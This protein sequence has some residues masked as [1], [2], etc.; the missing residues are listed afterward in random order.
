M[1]ARLL[2]VMKKN[3]ARRKYAPDHTGVCC[4]SVVGA[5]RWVAVRAVIHA[6][7]L[8]VS[9]ALAFI[10]LVLV[11]PA[12]VMR[13]CCLSCWRACRAGACHALRWRSGV[14]FIW[15]PSWVWVCRAGV[16]FVL[17]VF[18]VCCA[19]RFALKKGICQSN[20]CSIGKK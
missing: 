5:V 6:G 3:Y 8:C 10:V 15:Y 2:A 9:V 7:V 16:V 18:V 17:L 1:S 20:S 13:G 14:V 11:V 4:A 12:F 19:G